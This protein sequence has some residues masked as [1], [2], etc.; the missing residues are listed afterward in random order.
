MQDG[1]AGFTL[2]KS[3][4]EAFS[5][6]VFAIAITLLIL[7]VN[8]PANIPDHPTRQKQL[9]GILTIWSQYLVYAATFAT[10]GTM[11][12]NHHALFRYVERITH[13]IVIAN[14]LLLGLVCFLPFSTEVIARYGLTQVS[15]V[16]YG[17]VLT[18]I[19][20][21]YFILQRQVMAAHPSV[22]RRVTSW[23]LVGLSFYPVAIVL[24]FFVPVLG[25]VICGLAALFYLLPR[26]VASAAIRP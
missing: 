24:G 4:F 22:D 13:G 25:V 8:V 19:S 12:L 10:I 23:N 3:R 18:A 16:Y 15:V 2:S 21:G 6:G 9:E 17:L 5:D 1:E 26:S 7:Q 11:W 14:L 20:V